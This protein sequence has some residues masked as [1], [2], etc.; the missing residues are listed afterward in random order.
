MPGPKPLPNKILALRGSRL[1]DRRPAEGPSPV[2]RPPCPAWLPAEAKRVY[3]DLVAALEVAGRLGEVDRALLAATAEAAAEH[4]RA[5]EALATDGPVVRY[6]NG[7]QGP[8]P[9]AKVR[10]SAARRLRAGLADLGLR[11]ADRSPSRPPE[12][13]ALTAWKRRHER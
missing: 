11:P 3:R 13:D 10:D 9:W 8:S 7:N 1:A 6:S 12:E 4:R 5:V 2:R